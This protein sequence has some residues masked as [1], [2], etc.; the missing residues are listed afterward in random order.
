MP[1]SNALRRDKISSMPA[2]HPH[3]QVFAKESDKQE[4]V[5]GAVGEILR[6]VDSLPTLNSKAEDE[7]LGYNEEG[8][9]N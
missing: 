9:P 3:R 8:I 4:Q 2:E 5:K 6:R 1:S 7:I